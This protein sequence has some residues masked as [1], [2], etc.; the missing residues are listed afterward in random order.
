MLVDFVMFWQN[1]ANSLKPILYTSLASIWLQLHI[2]HKDARVLLIISSNSQKKCILGL[3]TKKKSNYSFK[4]RESLSLGW[5]NDLRWLRLNTTEVN[6]FC[7][8]WFNSVLPFLI[9]DQGHK[10]KSRCIAATSWEAV[11]WKWHAWLVTCSVSI[12]PVVPLKTF[13]HYV[14]TNIIQPGA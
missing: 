14:P 6:T 4:D 3:F 12:L 2:K 13:P 10:H 5:R 1:Q 9:S 8:S 7:V 11:G